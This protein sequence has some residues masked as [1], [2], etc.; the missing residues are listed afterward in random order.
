MKLI[1]ISVKIQENMVTWPG[2]PKVKIDWVA[3]IGEDSDANI[4]ALSYGLHTGT[5]IDV[6]LH[7]VKNGWS[8]DDLDLGVLIGT[9]EVVQLPDG[10][11]LIGREDLEALEIGCFER[12]LFKTRNSQSWP[13]DAVSFDKDF[14]A[15][16][17]SGADYLVEK[18]CKLVGID[19][20]SIAPFNDPPT[21]HKRLLEAGVVILEGLDLSEA[22]PGLYELIC[23]P[24]KLAGREGAPAR[25]VLRPLAD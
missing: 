5:H 8:M 17:P 14:V 6:P 12:V 15:L 21:T 20:L 13:K 10:C 23:L 25:A 9:C 4:S 24:V 1:D 11:D 22:E 19:Y 18:G 2:D 3:R 16:G 7:F